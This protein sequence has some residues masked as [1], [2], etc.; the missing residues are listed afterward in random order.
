MSPFFAR[1]AV[2][3]DWEQNGRDTLARQRTGLMPETPIRPGQA[4]EE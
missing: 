3:G 2:A 1:R 4:R